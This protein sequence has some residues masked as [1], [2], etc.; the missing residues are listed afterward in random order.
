MNPTD[1]DEKMLWAVIAA[2]APEPKDIGPEA[3]LA[4]RN[5]DRARHPYSVTVDENLLTVRGGYDR[6]S[7][8]HCEITVPLPFIRGIG[9]ICEHY[10]KGR[11]SRVNLRA[12][13]IIVAGQKD[14][15]NIFQG[16]PV[17]W[18][19][20]GESLRKSLTEQEM[21]W[22][23]RQLAMV[24]HE[25]LAAVNAYINRV[26]ELDPQNRQLKLGL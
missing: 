1:I 9:S 7:D 25:V 15:V 21:I 4:K 18:Y 6:H 2:S 16:E 10:T 20:G 26:R 19:P 5:E 8:Y 22:H 11:G 17:W 24:R 12:F 3:Y 14:A 13:N 23:I